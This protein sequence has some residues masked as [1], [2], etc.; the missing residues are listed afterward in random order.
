MMPEE[1]G[2]GGVEDAERPAQEML[3]GEQPGVG[4]FEHEVALS[5]FTEGG[6]AGA[7]E[8]AELGGDSVAAV[9]RFGLE[10]RVTHVSTGGGASL[11]L[12]EG[13]ALP[14]VEALS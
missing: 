6:L 5:G 2:T 13:R 14:G 1:L 12:I 10:D 3:F 11:E 4:I 9:V 8:F 7:G